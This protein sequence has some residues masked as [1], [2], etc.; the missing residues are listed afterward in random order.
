MYLFHASLKENFLKGSNVNHKI[1]FKLPTQ[2]NWKPSKV[3]S[4]H[5]GIHMDDDSYIVWFPIN[6]TNEEDY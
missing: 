3:W 6:N 1:V 2:V 4:S 5:G